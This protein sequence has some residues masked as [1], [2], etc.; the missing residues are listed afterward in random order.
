MEVGA[1]ADAELREHLVQV[2]L[3][4]LG[5]DEELAADLLVGSARRA[6]G[7]R[8]GPPAA[9]SW[10]GRLDGAPAR[11][12]AR[13]QQLARGALGE[14]LGTHAANSVVGGSQLLARIEPPPLAAEPFAVQ[15]MGARQR[16]RAT[17]RGRAGR[18]PRG[19]DLVGRSSLSSARERASIPSAQSVPLAR[20]VSREALEG[21]GSSSASARGRP[22]RP[23]RATPGEDHAVVDPR[24]LARP[25]QRGVVAA[26]AVLEHR[27]RLFATVSPIPSPRAGHLPHRRPRSA[28][29][30]RLPPLKGSEQHAPSGASVV[31]VASVIANRPLRSA[32][33]PQRS[34]P[35]TAARPRQMRASGKTPSAPVSRAG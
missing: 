3:D 27:A 18:S 31:P 23:A 30:P 11:P 35:R 12:L 10:S 13:G 2:V 24:R 6:P 7:G 21:V 33:P 32:P 9:V 25:R 26:K 5:A 29:R 22:P 8:S 19:R 1:R 34:R 20:V 4:R 17:G 16:P 15:Q 14:G 28:P